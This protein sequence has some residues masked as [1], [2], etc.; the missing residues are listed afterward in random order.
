MEAIFFVKLYWQESE[1][2][3]KCTNDACPRPNL[4]WAQDWLRP[5]ANKDFLPIYIYLFAGPHQAMHIKYQLE[6]YKD[7]EK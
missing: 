7:K 4:Y 5:R 1:D 3:S 6:A 2:G